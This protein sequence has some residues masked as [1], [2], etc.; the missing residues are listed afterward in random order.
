MELSLLTT[1]GL[2]ALGLVVFLSGFW[3]SRSGIPYA[4]ALVNL[5]KLTDL[6]AILILGRP[7][8]VANR[9]VIG[10]WGWQRLPA[11]SASPCSSPAAC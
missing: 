9:V 1:A 8:Y 6:A 10:S 7:V 5:H 3:L 2:A 4:A 11:C